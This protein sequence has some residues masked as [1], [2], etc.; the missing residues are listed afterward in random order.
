MRETEVEPGGDWSG[1][2]NPEEPTKPET[3]LCE[4]FQSVI[5]RSV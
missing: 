4:I 5:F 2:W 3:D 1:D